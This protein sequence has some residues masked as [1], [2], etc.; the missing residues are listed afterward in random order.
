MSEVSVHAD[1]CAA[2]P[3]PCEPALRQAIQDYEQTVPDKGRWSRLLPL[4]PADDGHWE[5]EVIDVRGRTVLL[6]YVPNLGLTRE[7]DA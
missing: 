1:W 2:A 6:R 7:R 3:E 5:A 4:R